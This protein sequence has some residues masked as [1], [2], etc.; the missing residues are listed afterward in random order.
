M[1]VVRN[2]FETRREQPG[3]HPDGAR[4]GDR[5]SSGT[6]TATRPSAHASDIESVPIKR[7]QA[8]YHLYY[9]PD[10]AVLIVAGQFR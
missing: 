8:F 2:E 4:A 3:P 7:L 5:L 6:T 1:T 10:N 9:Q